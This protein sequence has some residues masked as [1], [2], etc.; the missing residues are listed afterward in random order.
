MITI[1]CGVSRGVETHTRAQ[2]NNNTHKQ[3]REHTN[4]NDKVT[5]QERAQISLQQ[6]KSVVVEFWS[7]SVLKVCMGNNSIRLGG[8]FIAPR[9]LGVIGASFG[10]SQPSL[11]AGSLDC[12]V[13]Y[14]TLDSAT[15]NRFPIGHFPF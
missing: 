6:I 2:C 7:S 9:D 15:V 11:S 12:P 13:A 10:S 4:Q 1:K 5:A 8:P 14:R 3:R